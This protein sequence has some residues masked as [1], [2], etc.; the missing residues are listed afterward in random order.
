M[1][2]WAVHAEGARAG[3]ILEVPRLDGTWVRVR[4]TKKITLYDFENID[5][6]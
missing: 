2:G 3:Q 5:E 4:L 1:N 6:S